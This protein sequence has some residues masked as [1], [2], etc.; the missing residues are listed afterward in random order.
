MKLLFVR[1]IDIYKYTNRD[2]MLVGRHI[3]VNVE[4]LLIHALHFIIPPPFA[5]SGLIGF[6]FAGASSLENAVP[7]S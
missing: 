4:P 7:L 3:S 6:T 2:T 1:Q 5:S